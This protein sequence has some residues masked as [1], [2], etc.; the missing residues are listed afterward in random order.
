MSYHQL[1]TFSGVFTFTGF[2]RGIK[3]PVRPM[4]ASY[5]AIEKTKLDVLGCRDSRGKTTR[6]FD[7][8]YAGESEWL[9]ALNPVLCPVYLI[10]NRSTRAEN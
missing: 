5:V 1:Q 3:S 7:K 8:I 10:L 4:T 2:A 6:V 9:W